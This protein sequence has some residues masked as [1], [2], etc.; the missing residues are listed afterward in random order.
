MPNYLNHQVQYDLS[1][2]ISQDIVWNKLKNKSILI[3]GATGMLASYIGF[4]LLHLNKH[5]NLNISIILL[6]RSQQKISNIYGDTLP[7]TTVLL[8]DI[9]EAINLKKPI[10]YIFHAAGAANPY[11]IINDPIGIILANTIGTKNV[12]DLAL[13][14]NTSNIVFAST[15]E[16]YGEVKEKLI[17]KEDDMGSLDPLNPRNCYPESK[18]LAES[19]LL[20]YNKQFSVNFNSLRIAHTYGPG[21]QV[22]N[23]G[24]VLSDFLNDAINNRDIKMNSTGEAERSFCYIT[25]AVSGIFRVMLAGKPSHAYNLA[26]E[27]E[28]IRLIDLANKIQTLAGNNKSVQINLADN[29]AG[30]TNYKRTSLCTKKIQSLNWQAT[31][32][33]EDGLNRTLKFFNS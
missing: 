10:D 26:N 21:M 2:L 27:Q 12:L 15:R 25:D 11:N 19:M 22:E 3:T 23:D 8:Q 1:E 29:S 33:L 9:T 17:I 30:Y 28:P 16:I 24:R 13:N 5:L 32:S 7:N 6:A 14:S 31:I 18:R 20:A 4:T